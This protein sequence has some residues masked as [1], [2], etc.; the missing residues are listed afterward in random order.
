[1]KE[2]VEV[3]GHGDSFEEW[4]R[5]TLTLCANNAHP[6]ADRLLLDGGPASHSHAYSVHTGAGWLLPGEQG[7]DTTC[8]G[9]RHEHPEH[10]QAACFLPPAEAAPP[11]SRAVVAS[12]SIESSGLHGM[13]SAVKCGPSHT[14]AAHSN[15]DFFLPHRH[16]APSVMSTA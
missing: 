14:Y 13:R 1:M 12:D 6:S 15:I 11:S 9:I 10:P 8:E 3:L 2:G 5:S 16:E 4:A 7:D